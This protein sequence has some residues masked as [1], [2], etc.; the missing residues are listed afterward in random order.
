MDLHCP[1]RIQASLLL[2]LLVLLVLLLLLL[3]LEVLC[4][5][6]GG[7]R[8]EGVHELEV[9]ESFCQEGDVLCHGLSRRQTSMLIFLRVLVAV[10][11]L[12]E[13]GSVD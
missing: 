11:L 10:D 2:L 7:D 12:G 4:G 5:G 8:A 6:W 1:C 3:R 13:N 9:R